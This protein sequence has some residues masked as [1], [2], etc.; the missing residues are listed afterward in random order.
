MDLKVCCV[1]LCL[2]S[3]AELF[4]LGLV[5]VN[6]AILLVSALT[7]GLAMLALQAGRIGAIRHF[8]G[9]YLQDWIADPDFPLVWRLD[10]T[11]AGSG[12]H[13]PAPISRSWRAS[14]AT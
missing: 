14:A 3:T 12:A 4:D 8:R 1:V 7:C 9:T 11:Q 6:T 2:R 5:A 13:V 10:K